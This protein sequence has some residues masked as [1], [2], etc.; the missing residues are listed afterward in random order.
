M[1]L[2][3]VD[4]KRTAASVAKRAQP[5]LGKVETFYAVLSRV[6]GATVLDYTRGSSTRFV[7]DHGEID[8]VEQTP[9]KV[10]GANVGDR[11]IVCGPESA[12]AD[13]VA[14]AEILRIENGGMRAVITKIC[15]GAV[16]LGPVT[17]CPCDG[18]KEEL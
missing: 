18:L 10:C 11:V 17:L 15:G 13:A 3:D 16:P 14:V 9:Y 4:A 8:H 7:D 12:G 1:S 2:A 6:D 5:K